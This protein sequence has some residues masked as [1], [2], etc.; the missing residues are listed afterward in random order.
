[1]LLDALMMGRCSFRYVFTRL[2]KCTSPVKT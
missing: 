1:V 2:H